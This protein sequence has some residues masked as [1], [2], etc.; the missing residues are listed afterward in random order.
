VL[1][2]IKT[3]ST[4]NGASVFLLCPFFE[5]TEG[6]GGMQYQTLEPNFQLNKEISQRV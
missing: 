5:S 4:E 6:E 1:V 2:H 3:L